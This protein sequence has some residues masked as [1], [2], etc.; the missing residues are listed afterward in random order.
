MRGDPGGRERVF[1]Q[2][3]GN[4][5]RGNFQ[6]RVVE[7]EYKLIVDIFKDEQYLELYDVVE[8]PEE[9]TNLAFDPR[10]RDRLN[11]LVDRLRDHMVETGDLLTLRENTVESFAN[12]Y[13]AV[14]P[15]LRR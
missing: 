11:T 4:G 15:S 13:A 6:P 1:I 10:H 14:R 12:D 3:D 8:D 9:T 7:G 2:F 5:A